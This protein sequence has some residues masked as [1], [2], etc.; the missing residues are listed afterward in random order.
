MFK[1]K[2]SKMKE[3]FEMDFYYEYQNIEFIQDGYYKFL[4]IKRETIK[5]DYGLFKQVSFFKNND[6]EEFNQMPRPKNITISENFNIKDDEP[7]KEKLTEQNIHN[8]MNN[9]SYSTFDE[10]RNSKKQNSNS[11]QVFQLPIAIEEISCSLEMN[12]INPSEY[13]ELSISI[14][15]IEEPVEESIEEV[16]EVKS[17]W[18]MGYYYQKYNNFRG[19]KSPLVKE[20]RI[21]KLIIKQNSDQ[22]LQNRKLY[23]KNRKKIKV[24]RN[25]ALKIIHFRY[26]KILFKRWKIKSKFDK[27]NKYS[28]WK[29]KNDY[30]EHLES[31]KRYKANNIK[32]VDR[33]SSINFLKQR[34]DLC[35]K[36]SNKLT[37]RKKLNFKDFEIVNPSFIEIKELKNDLVKLNQL[38]SV[39]IDLRKSKKSIMIDWISRRMRES[40][41]LYI[42]SENISK[43]QR[44]QVSKYKEKLEAENNPEK[45]S[46][47]LGYVYLKKNPGE[48]CDY[49]IFDDSWIEQQSESSKN[50]IIFKQNLTSVTHR[51]LYKDDK[52]VLIACSSVKGMTPEEI[53][54]SKKFRLSSDLMFVSKKFVLEKKRF[55]KYMK[56]R[57]R[58]EDWAKKI[59]LN[60]EKSKET[61]ESMDFNELL[62]K[63]EIN[64][65]KISQDFEEQKDIASHILNNR[66]TLVKGYSQNYKTPFLYSTLKILVQT[67][68]MKLTV[69]KQCK[70]LFLSDDPSIVRKLAIQLHKSG[71]QVCIFQIETQIQKKDFKKQK[72]QQM[73][74]KFSFNDKVKKSRSE[75]IE[76]KRILLMNCDII[77]CE[78]GNIKEMIRV[79]KSL[80]KMNSFQ[81]LYTMVYSSIQYSQFYC[82]TILSKNLQ[83]LVYFGKDESSLEDMVEGNDQEEKQGEESGDL[84]LDQNQPTEEKEQKIKCKKNY[85]KLLEVNESSVLT[86]NIQDDL[87]REILENMDVKEKE[88]YL[89]NKNR[90][91][92]NQKIYKRVFKEKEFKAIYI[93]YG[94]EFEYN[95]K[96]PL[97]IISNSTQIVLTLFK[98]FVRTGLDT[99]ELGVLCFDDHGRD[100]IHDKFLKKY[101]NQEQ[102]KIELFD[103]EN[104]ICFENKYI[105]VDCYQGQHKDSNILKEEIHRLLRQDLQGIIIIGD[106]YDLRQNAD[107]KQ[108]LENIKERGSYREITFINNNNFTN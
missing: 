64:E 77:L 104:R 58:F 72:L 32:P 73:I 69:S 60:D 38:I 39:P 10:D 105:I 81:Y 63:N 2:Q 30:Y 76:E 12:S 55:D 56:L 92:I 70:V 41:F 9:K 90:E 1:I 80:F 24:L 6:I 66:I 79:T 103:Q 35:V 61:Q 87:E 45:V 43:R 97:K 47:D 102:L 74:E 71:V 91:K 67:L 26:I 23:Y 83:K 7:D 42:E 101:K 65:S 53:Y 22:R 4:Q 44:I 78:L 21:N 68:R 14:E 40:Q 50:F 75:I 106:E 16:K 98:E 5:F 54:N 62:I 59:I 82:G 57:R 85:E 17:K 48:T 36:R 94:N 25:T 84:D 20:L 34:Y 8:D 49:L 15:S 27:R 88:I 29:N 18:S 52:K 89:E 46:F 28:D 3:I 31:R 33:D 86:L 108:V 37:N 100:A 93:G 107:L 19:R 96:D 11:L 13:Q 95:K 99:S 51:V